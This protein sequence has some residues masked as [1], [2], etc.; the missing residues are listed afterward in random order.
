MKQSIILTEDG[1]HSIVMP[2]L[3]VSY[4]SRHGALQESKH[5]FI[6]AGLKEVLKKKNDIAVFEMGFGT[7]LNA[8]LTLIETENISVNIYYETAELYPVDNSIASQLNY[9]DALSR[10]DMHP[11]FML[12]HECAW[13]AT[14][15]ISGK[16]TLYKRNENIEQV[17]LTNKFDIVYFDAFDPVAQPGLWTTGV[18]RKL[19]NVMN[20]GGLLLTYCSKVVVRR[21]MEEAGFSVEKIPGPKGK[22]EIVRAFVR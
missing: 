1:S 6:E 11:Q 22:R 19:F 21:A 17:V 12:M 18:F 2:Q 15:A 3:N 8:L 9:T 4:H 16:F 13:G 20:E 10:N 7:G 14:C 5:I